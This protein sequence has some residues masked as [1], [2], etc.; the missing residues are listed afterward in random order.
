MAKGSNYYNNQYAEE[1]G[2]LSNLVEGECEQVT[3]NCSVKTR[4]FKSWC[5]SLDTPNSPDTRYHY[6][7]YGQIHDP[8]GK[9][10]G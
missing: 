6:P 5:N 7:S 4:G 2:F 1:P 9:N 8:K 10:G 3:P